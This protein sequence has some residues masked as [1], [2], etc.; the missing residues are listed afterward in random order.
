MDYNNGLPIS[1]PSGYVGYQHIY[2]FG[3]VKKWL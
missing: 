2:V 1:S 3:S